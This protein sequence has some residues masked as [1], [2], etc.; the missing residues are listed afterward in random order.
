[1]LVDWAMLPNDIQHMLLHIIHHRLLFQA[2]TATLGF[3]RLPST[4]GH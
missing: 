4:I 1:M 3:T 2:G